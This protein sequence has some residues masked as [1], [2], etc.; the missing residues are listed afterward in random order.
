MFS[1]YEY[2]PVLGFFGLGLGISVLILVLSKR[3]DSPSAMDTEK[4]SGYECGFDPFDHAR[5]PFDVRFYLVG[6]LFLIF[7]L[8]ATFVF[9]WSL[10]LGSEIFEVFDTSAV[11]AA[12]WSITDFLF[13]LLVGYV[14][15]WRA[16]ALQW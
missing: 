11:S 2:S 15:C 9:P 12:F 4:L 3:F 13:E 10:T 14:Y 7:D 6:I 8:E 1:I 16:G 5:A